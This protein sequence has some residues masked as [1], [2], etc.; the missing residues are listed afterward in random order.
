MKFLSP[1]PIALGV[2]HNSCAPKLQWVAVLALC[3]KREARVGKCLLQFQI[4]RMRRAD[5]D[6]DRERP[7]LKSWCRDETL[8]PDSEK[9]QEPGISQPCPP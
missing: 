8:R 5:W 6:W 9:G 4:E 1:V 2:V 3:A 7:K